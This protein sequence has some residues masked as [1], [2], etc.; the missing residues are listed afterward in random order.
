MPMTHRIEPFAGLLYEPE[1]AGVL[2]NVVA[3]PY[4][5][6]DKARQDALYAGSLYNVVRLELNRD[7]DRYDSAARTLDEWLKDGVLKRA[8]RPAIYFYS[9]FFEIEGR[10]LRRDGFIVRVR[11][12]EFNAG[13]ILPHERTFPAAK[14]DRLELLTALDT[15]VSSVFGLYAGA[16]PAL[17][18]L[19]AE[20]VAR[21]PTLE[22]TD[23]LGIRNQLSLIEDEAAIAAIQEELESPRI[24]IADGH[25]R[26]ETALE[27]RRRRRVAEGNP[28]AARPY[29]YT[30]MTLVACDDPGLV[31]LPTYRVVRSLDP[32]TIAS[33]DA[34]VP[35]FFEVEEFS[36][37]EA[38]RAALAKAERGAI[39][40]ALGG[41]R[42]KLRLLRL[43]DQ[44]A[45][46]DAMP[47]APPAV[48]RLDV[49]VL[50]ALVLERIFE[51]TPE[52]IKA[53]GVIE[54]TIDALGAL[55]AVGP[56]TFSGAFLMNPP[57]IADV[58]SVADAGAVM[59]EKSTYFYPKLLTGL[60]LNPLDDA[61]P[62]K[63]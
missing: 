36:S 49:S 53:G 25:H 41:E 5:L 7:P 15:N 1:R 56:G 62:A 11:L 55:G 60:V 51:I 42:V 19:T 14:Q 3:P 54:Y 57:A 34:R 61:A 10:L 40:V 4:D 46:D 20:L 43:K 27:Y 13:R 21:E 30:M 35:P 23:D 45:M 29:D 16:H 28:A 32:E 6:I 22:V 63:A 17:T 58:E 47:E 44:R 2:S 59:P 18:A 9:Q 8:P 26:Y 12:E 39:A 38:M 48:Q 24:F 37:P 50:H 31:I 52:R 33:F